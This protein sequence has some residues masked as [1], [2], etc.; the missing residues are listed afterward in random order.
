MN[1]GKNNLE[2]KKIERWTLGGEMGRG[3][4]TRKERGMYVVV[5]T[6]EVFYNGDCAWEGPFYRAWVGYWVCPAKPVYFWHFIVSLLDIND[7]CRKSN[8]C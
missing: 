4:R 8:S 2:N 6:N 5:W 1:I 3:F 7:Y